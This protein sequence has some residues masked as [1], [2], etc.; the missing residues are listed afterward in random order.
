MNVPI[1]NEFRQICMIIFGEE[2]P[3]SIDDYGKWLGRR[4]PLPIQTKSVLSG[5]EVWVPPGDNY[6]KKTLD[7]T[8]T[9][10]MDEKENVSSTTLHP[11]DISGL[12]AR[13]LI[14][15]A[16]SPI[17]YYCGNFRYGDCQNI[18]KCSGGGG[19]NI[20]YCEDVY[21]GAKNCAYSN[22]TSYSENMFGCNAAPF[23]KFCIHAY[24][25]SNLTRCFEVDGCTNS[26]DLLF[27]HN[28]EG[29]S[30]AILCFNVKS[31]KY[32]VGNVEVGREQFMRIKKILVERILS[33]LKQNQ[34]FD[35]DIYNVGGL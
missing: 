2:L 34:S 21:F 30:N 6:L 15:K 4:V 9:I 26:S 35:I 5:K 19:L 28:C 17:A 1:E 11:E 24:H 8:R 14:R 16:V 13:S 20:Y 25:S 18:E 33:D 22:F 29:M 10:S 27:C 12:D 32:A 7:S 23:S 3:G 31:M